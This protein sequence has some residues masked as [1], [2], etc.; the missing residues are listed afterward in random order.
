MIKHL[1]VLDGPSGAGKT[2]L[3]REL[4]EQ[5]L[6][7]NWLYFSL[8]TFTSTLPV[9]VLAQCQSENDWQDVDSSTL[10]QNALLCV[11]TLLKAGNNVIFDSVISTS[12]RALQIDLAFEQHDRF[13][14]GVHCE[15]SELERRAAARNDR[16][17]EQARHSFATAPMHLIYDLEIDSTSTSVKELATIVAA[18]MYEQKH[19]V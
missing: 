13:Y 17:I 8:D 1:I 14:V 12:K 5:L 4:Q 6:N 7:D 18:T 10:L 15:L 19:D 16:T 3:A 2:S 9:S 11:D